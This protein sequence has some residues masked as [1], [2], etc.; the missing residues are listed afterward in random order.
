ML[1]MIKFEAADIVGVKAT[2]KVSKEDYQEVIE[3]TLA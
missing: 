3:P 2:G 1:E